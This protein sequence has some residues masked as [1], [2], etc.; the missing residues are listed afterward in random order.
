MGDEGDEARDRED[1]VGG[2][3]VLA[4]RAAAAG[5]EAERARVAIES[6][7]SPKVYRLIQAGALQMGGHRQEITVLKTDI[8][9][10]TSLSERLEPE[11][12]VDHL[13][14]FAIEEL[15]YAAAGREQDLE[16]MKKFESHLLKARMFG[17]SRHIVRAEGAEAFVAELRGE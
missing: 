10:F 12:I 9:D 7:M 6:Y 5:A 11:E 16:D 8:R 3:A 17:R 13:Q 2:S 4:Q 15:A 1:Q 14:L